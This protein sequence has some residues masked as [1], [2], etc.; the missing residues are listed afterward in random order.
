MGVLTTVLLM[1]LMLSV[2]RSNLRMLS[3]LVP[4]VLYLE[5][6]TPGIVGSFAYYGRY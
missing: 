5:T 4:V 3:V 1:L 2:L 6:W